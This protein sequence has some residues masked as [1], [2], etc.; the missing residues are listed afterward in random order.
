MKNN[1]LR[2]LNISIGF[3]FI[4]SAI[5]KLIS[6]NSFELYVY[7]FGFFGL[8]SSAFIARFFII[9]EL[10]IGT[11][12]LLNFYPRF[13]RISSILLLSGFSVFLLY[14]LFFY[15]NNDNCHCFGDIIELNPLPSLI[16]NIVLII[17]L[18]LTRNTIPFFYK[19]GKTI[20]I[21]IPI[22]LSVGILLIFPLDNWFTKRNNVDFN[23][24][25][26]IELIQENKFSEKDLEGQ[27]V[28]CFFGL[29][30]QYCELA[31]KK[32][33]LIQKNHPE[34]KMDFIGIFWGGN[35]QLEKFQEETNL[36]YSNILFID[37]I[38]FLKITDGKMPLIVILDN[39]LP[40]AYFNYTSLQENSLIK[41][42][43]DNKLTIE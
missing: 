35:K 29:G 6:I 2:I 3:I 4:A 7:S 11:G 28:I 40:I 33:Y 20:S 41:I 15:G 43:K 5:L 34:I 39:Q 30:C 24:S 38:Q 25:A 32:L 17:I 8:N 22:I 37:P 42:L 14:T 16:K 10:I 31:A 27:K 13:F 12:L 21:S 26:F 18:L 1:L 9:L 19:R 23:E 36:S